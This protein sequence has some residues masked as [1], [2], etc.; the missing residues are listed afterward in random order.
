MFCFHSLKDIKDFQV[1]FTLDFFLHCCSVQETH[2]FL[3]Y[4]WIRA[5]SGRP[6]LPD[7]SLPTSQLLLWG[8]RGFSTASRSVLSETLFTASELVLWSLSSG[9]D[10][11]QNPVIGLWSLCLG[12]PWSH[13][14]TWIHGLRSLNKNPSVHCIS[15]Q[16][17][18]SLEGWSSIL[19][20]EY[21]SCS[22]PSQGSY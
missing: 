15:S 12:P 4:G 6:L 13:L 1:R 17:G 22:F 7:T 16:P 5:S 10:S 9:W 11:T 18:L 14:L 20:W 19:S 3:D 8:S 2:T 21:M